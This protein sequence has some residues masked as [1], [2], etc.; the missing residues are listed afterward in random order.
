MLMGESSMQGQF[1]VLSQFI[2]CMTWFLAINLVSND[3]IRII[4]MITTNM[5][6]A[7]SHLLKSFAKNSAN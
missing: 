6:I 3:K 1:A 5:A 4:T 2:M 7:I